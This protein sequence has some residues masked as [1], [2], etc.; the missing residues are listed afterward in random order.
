MA[1]PTQQLG[2]LASSS[3]STAAG[4]RSVSIDSSHNSLWGEDLDTL[5]EDRGQDR[6]R[7]SSRSGANAATARRPFEVV[8]GGGSVEVVRRRAAA[9]EA[10][11]WANLVVSAAASSYAAPAAF[12]A[13]EGGDGGSVEVVRTSPGGSEDMA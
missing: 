9:E 11:T 12:E 6:G 5:W 7:Q 10:G 13:P 3:S 4:Q 2:D 8:G 1:P